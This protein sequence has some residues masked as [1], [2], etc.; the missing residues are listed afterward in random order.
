MNSTPNLGN[1]NPSQTLLPIPP[2]NKTTHY[3]ATATKAGQLEKQL[4]GGP[5]S[6]LLGIVLLS[7][8]P[9][10]FFSIINVSFCYLFHSNA[11][12]TWLIVL[13]CGICSFLFTLVDQRNKFG[14]RWYMKLGILCV[15]GC[16]A[17]V[18]LG[19]FNYHYHYANYWAYAENAEYSNVL[20]SEDA[21]AHADAGKIIFSA[22]AKID[23]NKILG[24]KSKRVFCVAPIVDYATTKINYWAAGVDCCGQRS[25]FACDDA[26]NTKARSGVVLLDNRG[27]FPEEHKYFK[28]AAEQA[29]AAYGLEMADEPL[30]VRWVANPDLVQ[31]A[32]FS[33]GFGYLVL[34]TIIGAVVAVLVGA[35]V[36]VSSRKKGESVQGVSLPSGV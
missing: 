34:F 26:Y 13:L 11:S 17:G 36:Q 4:G 1:Q 33:S 27:V 3:N 2:R 10:L 15:F 35:L 23:M 6:T 14:G 22:D 21:A 29:T 12:V 25:D 32:Y 8:L 9:W 5:K 16:G 18:V 19:M 31:D 20:P 28:L 24:Y 30:F 7:G